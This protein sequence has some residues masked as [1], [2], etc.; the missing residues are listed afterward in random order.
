MQYQQPKIFPKN[1]SQNI[2]INVTNGSRLDFSLLISSKIPNLALF[3]LDPIQSFPLERYI[4]D[5]NKVS[6]ITEYGLKKFQTHYNNNDIT[7]E[8]IFNYCYGVLHYPAYREKYQINLKQDLPRIPFYDNFFKFVEIGK[9]LIDIHINFETIE[10]YPLKQINI[11]T[12]KPNIPKLKLS[13]D[14][15]EIIIDEITTLQNFQLKH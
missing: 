5:E 8:N 14:K 12:K 13:N 2:V 1:N 9:K 11:K 6:N 4:D 15:T 10:K 7:K 3:S